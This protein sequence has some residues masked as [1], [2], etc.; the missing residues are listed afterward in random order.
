VIKFNHISP[1][2]YSRFTYILCH[3]MSPQLQNKA[4]AA[5]PPRRSS[6]EFF[7]EGSG[8]V[9]A[10]MG[11]VPIPLLCLVVRI[12]GRDV[13]PSLD[14]R[15]PSGWVLV[16][17]LWLTCCALKVLT[18]MTLLGYACRRVEHCPAEESDEGT[19]FLQGVE[20]FT[21]HKGG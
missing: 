19:R 5:A 13:Y 15:H 1:T 2:V 14:M 20:R 4:G 10:R 9:C 18:S 3:S 12:V 7:H 8:A 11:F 6:I 16:G 21:S 17:L